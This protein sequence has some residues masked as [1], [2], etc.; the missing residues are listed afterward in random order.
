M[1]RGRVAIRLAIALALAAVVAYGMIAAV[2]TFAVGPVNTYDFFFMLGLRLG[3][4]SP[5]RT[6]LPWVVALDWSPDGR[7]LFAS[8]YFRQILVFD[9]AD[10]T[11]ARRLGGHDNW[12]QEVIHSPSGRYLASGDW[13]GRVVVRD[14]DGGGEG[15]FEVGSDVYSISFSPDESRVAVSDGEGLVHVFDLARNTKVA[16]FPGNEGGT[17]YLAYAPGGRHLATGG[18]DAMVRLFDPETL[19]P[20]GTPLEHGN[21]VTSLS[22]DATGERLL[23]C[24]DDGF[25]RY[26]NVRE[27]REIRAWAADPSWVSFCT[28][29]PNSPSFA[30]AG[31]DGRVRLGR[32]DRD[33]APRAIDAGGGWLQCV[34]PRRD[35]GAIAATDHR[36]GIWIY[37]LRG[38]T[39]VRVIDVKPLLKGDL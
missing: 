21:D 26:W 22:F 19:R 1:S 35:G 39:V 14:L 36:G 10:G 24:G 6:V 3:A 30:A 2:A 9:V 18:E 13:G 29:I 8:G 15:A 32:T 11:L 20:N 27:G 23:S 17:L 25:V 28:L 16:E 5:A 37:D 33:D 31:S 34:R 7:F 4:I 12:I 38:E